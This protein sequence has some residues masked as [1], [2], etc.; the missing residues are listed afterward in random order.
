[1]STIAVYIEHRD[2]KVRPVS[3]EALTAAKK[4]GGTVIGVLAGENVSALAA[5]LGDHGADEVHVVNSP[6]LAKFSVQGYA[7][8]FAEAAKQAG[9]TL[10]LVTASSEGNDIAPRVAAKLD[11]GF[12]GGVSSIEG[13]AD[14]P[15]VTRPVY[16]GKAIAELDLGA[17]VKVVSIRP[18]AIMAEGGAGKAGTVKEVSVAIDG[19]SIRAHVE[20]VE[21]P[22]GGKAD[23]TEAEII[24][25][26]GRGMKGPENYALLEAL[27]DQ[28]GGVVGASRASVDS[29][30]RPHSDQVGQT[31]KTVS[32]NVYIA[33]GIS[34][35]IQHLAGMSNSKHIIAVNKD[36]DAPIFEVA[37][38]GCVGDLFEVIPA[39]TEKVKAA[40]G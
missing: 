10:L 17:G 2:G 9:A 37:S 15:K 29:G 20:S 1:M 6:A 11:A 23:L 28:L 18:K 25:S 16:S 36:G 35:A 22:A 39:L 38:L 34:G 33:A 24:V 14:S 19:G 4:L 27:A 3:F 30:W 12:A 5:G 40:K 7:Q 13:S 31:G 21:A 8:A 26:G 32:P